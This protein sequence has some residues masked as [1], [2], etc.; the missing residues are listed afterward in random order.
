[1]ERERLIKLIWG[2]LNFILL[3]AASFFPIL[4]Q[5]VLISGIITNI[6]L[7]YQFRYVQPAM[8]MMIFCLSYLGFLTPYYFYNYTIAEHTKYYNSE[9]FNKALVIHVLF[10]TSFSVFLK[11]QLNSSKLL[12]KNLIPTAS[13]PIIFYLLVFAMF[14]LLVTVKGESVIS[15]TGDSYQ[16]YIDNIDAQGGSLEYFYILYISAF[17]FAN[18]KFQKILLILIF[19]IYSYN[20]AIRGYRIQMVQMVFLAFVLFFDGKFKNF[21]LVFMCF[22]GF[23]MSEILS[24]LKTL[25]TVSMESLA[26]AFEFSG[27][28]EVIITNQTDVFYS[29]VVFLGLIEDSILDI[30][31]RIWSALGF[32][33]NWFLPSSFV[34]KEARLPEFGHE[35][36]TFGGGG[37]VSVYFFVWFG[38]LGV[39]VLGA[40]LAFCFNKLF[41]GAIRYY[42]VIGIMILS[43]YPRWFAYDPGNFLMRFSLYMFVFFFILMLIDKQM[44]SNSL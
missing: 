41:T 33:L 13:N 44:K 16:T 20:C 10:L 38:Y 9:L 43:V 8:I 42:N 1:M 31:T 19:L 7:I 3:L 5:V 32:I 6:F 11:P 18:K 15:T 34:W 27:T 17:F 2:G 29:S 39:V 28:G 25:G 4:I 12:I 24:I 14:T 21:F 22:F 35:F 26:K 23:I 30:Q 36:T 37:L 40:S